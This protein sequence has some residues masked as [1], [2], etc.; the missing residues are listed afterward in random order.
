MNEANIQNVIK[1]FID[2][3]KNEHFLSDV[4][5]TAVNCIVNCRTASM[6]AH[7]SECSECNTKYIHYNS[8]KNRHCPM[9]QGIE[10]N[11]WIDKRQ[12]D[13]LEAPYYHTVFTVPGELYPLIYSNQ[14][15]LYNL[16]YNAASQTLSELSADNKYLGAKIGYICVLHTWGS[17]LNYH[18][19]IH[20]IVL[21]GGLDK[22]NHWKDKNG[23]YLFPVQVMSDVFKKYFLKGLKKLRKN[24]CLEYKGDATALRNHYNFKEMLDKLFDRKWVV[25]TK[26]TFNGAMSVI[27]YLGN[28]THRSAISN[29]RI[30]SYDNE[31]VTFMAKNYKNNARYESETIKGTEFIRR[32]LMHVLPKG[33]V[34]IRYYGLLSCR[35]KT[36]KM[37]LCRNLLG[38]RQYISKLKN[39]SMPEK[40]KILFNVDVCKC[41][42]C[43]AELSTYKIPGIY[44]LC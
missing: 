28:Y 25:Y 7:V 41:R 26:E 24:K 18:P 36:E 10:T 23:E 4:Q 22:N 15:L 42:N 44:M 2:N 32:F 35:T 1:Q 20:T 14:K 29:K 8:C 19:H 9:C 37:T 3:Y 12:E 38:C 17:K 33:F 43:G 11:E 5:K 30:I 13:V 6:G 21:G 39:K 34:R 16:M 31:N 27:K 40:L